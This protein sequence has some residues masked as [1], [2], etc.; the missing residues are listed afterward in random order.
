MISLTKGLAKALAP[1]VQVNCINPGP[2]LIPEDYDE[3]QISL[4]IEKTLLKRVGKAKDVAMAV[5]FLLE[6]GDYIT[7]LILSVDGGRSIV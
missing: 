4:A 3:T 1:H 5:R 2:V 6:D 7:G